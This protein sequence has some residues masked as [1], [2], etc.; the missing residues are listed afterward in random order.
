MTKIEDPKCDEWTTK[1]NSLMLQK[2]EAHQSL[3]LPPYTCSNEHGQPCIQDESFF[4][5]VPDACETMRNYE[6]WPGRFILD[7]S[8]AKDGYDLLRVLG[9]DSKNRVVVIG[10]SLVTQIVIGVQCSLRRAGMEA[11]EAR[12]RFRQWGW[13]RYSFDGNG[14]SSPTMQ[15]ARGSSN[16]FNQTEYLD[17]CWKTTKGFDRTV[18]GC[19]DSGENCES[20]NV[21]IVFM[22]NIEHY[23]N[24]E[25]LDHYLEE[26]RFIIEH[27][28]KK[29]ARVVVGTSPP[30]HFGANGVFSRDV[31]KTKL[32]EITEMNS[33]CQCSPTTADISQDQDW[34][35]YFAGV[36]ELAQ[37]P[38]V[39][40]EID[41]MRSSLRNH[42]GAHKGGWCG[43]YASREAGETRVD[44]RPCC[45][46]GHWCFDPALW[47]TH[48][49]A[50][51]VDLF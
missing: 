49:I 26:S 30:K 32:A 41:M 25:N 3:P 8:A 22:Y 31:Y 43:F 19:D 5:L 40:G 39:I 35:K 11:S 14:C 33:T 17:G 48:F 15:S 16:W 2:E 51:F 4:K 38:G 18:L 42:Y 12:S 45:D 27:A 44:Y 50:P 37:I 24:L 7:T 23:M 36:A 28:V 20:T 47:D 29:G 10:A 21:I 46:C 34:S 1:I 9:E 6:D 13:A